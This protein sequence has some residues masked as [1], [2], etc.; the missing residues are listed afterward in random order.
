MTLRW[1]KPHPPPPPLSQYNPLPPPAPQ[2]PTPPPPLS[3]YTP[4]LNPPPHRPHRRSTVTWLT[5]RPACSCRW[6]SRERLSRWPPG[7]RCTGLRPTSRCTRRSAGNWWR[8]AELRRGRGIGATRPAS[9]RSWPGVTS[10]HI[11]FAAHS[12]ITTQF[13]FARRR[14]VLDLGQLG[15]LGQFHLLEWF[16]G[17]NCTKG[18]K[19]ECSLVM[20]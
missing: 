5:D 15:Q 19:V 11:S 12:E 3:H 14:C 20:L 1:L 2:P 16:I 18:F 6:S 7:G 8:E 4:P 9:Q 13:F 10:T 17:R